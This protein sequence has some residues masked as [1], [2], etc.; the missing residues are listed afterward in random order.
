[1][2][3]YSLSLDVISAESS[4]QELTA[5]LGATPSE[6]S[7]DLGSPRARQGFWKETVWRLESDAPTSSSLEGHFQSL[8]AKIQPTGVLEASRRLENAK[9]L[10]NVAV[11]FSSPMCT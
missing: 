11:F 5:R 10:F 9:T 6:S 1:M 8:L 4:L 3:E 2:K 7:H